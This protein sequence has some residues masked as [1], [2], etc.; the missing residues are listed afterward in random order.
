[1]AKNDEGGLSPNVTLVIG[2]VLCAGLVVVVLAASRFKS[3]PP[4][5]PPPVAVPAAQSIN[6]TLKFSPGFLKA[7]LAEDAKRFNIPAPD[8]AAL[9]TP[10]VYADELPSPKTLKADKDQ[11][12]T[13]HLHISTQVSKEWS[14]TGAAQRMRVEHMMLSITNKSDRPVAYRVETSVP[15]NARC[16]NKGAIAQNA[17]ALR[18]NET[19]HRSECLWAKGSTLQIK[20]VEVMELPDIGYFYVSRLIPTQ[21]LLDERTTTGHEPPAKLKPCAFVPWREIRTS[22]EQKGGVTWADLID[23]YARHDCDEY[24]F[25]SSYRRWLKPGT[26]PSREGAAAPSEPQLEPAANSR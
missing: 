14:M 9:A 5:P 23:F 24:T 12:D 17:M 2:L 25:Y 20:S 11:L 21:A 13:P 1:M 4:P 19:I 16:K 15:D 3:A 26:L 6:T 8:P 7:K 18:P 22:A 10:L